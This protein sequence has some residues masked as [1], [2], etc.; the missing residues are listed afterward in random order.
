MKGRRRTDM[1]RRLQC[2]ALLLVITLLSG[3]FVGCG[4]KANSNKANS[5]TDIEILF[6]HSGY[7]KAW[8][9][10]LIDAFEKKYPEYNVYY[11]ETANGGLYRNTLGMEDIDTID[12]YLMPRG[13]DT[14]YLEPLDDVYDATIEGESKSLKEKFSREYLASER[15]EDGHYYYTTLGGGLE[16]IFYNKKMFEEAGIK[17]EPRTTDELALAASTLKD[18]GVVP[19]GHFKTS[20]YWKYY[21]EVLF[22]QY[23]GIEAYQNFYKNPTKELMLTK[24]GRYEA[25]KVYEK[26][27]GAQSVLP[28]S[29][30]GTHTAMQTKFLEGSFAMMYNGCWLGIEMSASDK[31]ENFKM[32][33]SP[34]ISSITDKL[35]TV[36]GESQLRKLITAID[37][38][39][40]GVEDISKYQSGANYVVDGKEIAA[41][42]WERVR[43]ARCMS[44]YGYLGQGSWIPKYSNAKEGAKEFL[45]FWFSDEGY[46]IYADAAHL[47]LPISLDEGE[48]DTSNWTEVEKNNK[49]LLDKTSFGICGP[50]MVSKHKIF[51][52]GG[53]QAFAG[54]E[55]IQKFCASNQDDRLTADQLWKKITTTIDEQYDDIWMAN[56]Q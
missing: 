19:F 42:D 4:K 6:W 15:A 39:V 28:G 45:K 2:V 37:N 56:I 12:L 32:M 20:G 33:R 50:S 24:D 17:Q 13:Y 21:S 8:L 46:K 23:E 29:N 25:L 49:D 3:C 36:K 1:K 38:V 55:Y 9:D 47:T 51:T 41:S 11:T 27:L 35:T 43:E 10:A 16:G 7:G 40:D 18:Q 34:V 53:A 52:Y 44:S 30:S 14:T 31:M 54:Q 22:A 48:I 26:I 5:T